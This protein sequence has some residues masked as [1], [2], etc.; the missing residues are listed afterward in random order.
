M[1]AVNRRV[2]LGTMG[3]ALLSARY[4]AAAAMERIG[5]ELYTVRGDLEKDFVKVAKSY[6]A[7]KRIAYGAWREFGVTPD[8]LKKAGIT[9]G[10]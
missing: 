2:F 3:A 4:A 10:S 5:V 6:S 9:R 7:R 8:V 1:S